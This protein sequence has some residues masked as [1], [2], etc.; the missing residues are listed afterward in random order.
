MSEE[1]TVLQE[2]LLETDDVL[3]QELL[4]FNPRIVAYQ[5]YFLKHRKFRP[6]Q[7]SRLAIICIDFLMRSDFQKQLRREELIAMDK[8]LATFFDTDVETFYSPCRNSMNSR[9]CLND[10]YRAA[11]DDL[12]EA[13]LRVLVRERKN[14]KSEPPS[15]KA[16]VEPGTRNSNES[17]KLT[18]G[19]LIDGQGDLMLDA[20]NDTFDERRARF[21]SNIESTKVIF[22]SYPVLKSTLGSVLIKADGEKILNNNVNFCDRW[23][24]LSRFI[25]DDAKIIKDKNFKFLLDKANDESSEHLIALISILTLAIHFSVPHTSIKT[26]DNVKKVIRPTKLEAQKIFVH[27][28]NESEKDEHEK[29]MKSECPIFLYFLGDLDNPTNIKAITCIFDKIE[30]HKNPFDGFDLIIKAHLAFEMEFNP[31]CGALYGLLL[32]LIYN[33]TTDK[34]ARPMLPAVTRFISRILYKERES[35][36]DEFESH[37]KIETD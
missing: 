21:K 13:G 10:A 26:P 15:K 30:E 16:K 20:W 7:L 18:Q 37:V 34:L 9:G 27:L 33:F 36:S 12:T 29:Y 32:K 17:L 3:L 8:T 31:K 23:M 1:N 5:R 28:V 4:L 19:P 6:G 25:Y 14:T 24:K 35:R 11:K 22:D 2:I